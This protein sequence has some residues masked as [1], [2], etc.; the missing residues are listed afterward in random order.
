[1]FAPDSVVPLTAVA[2]QPRFVLNARW[3]VK[4]SDG[5]RRGDYCECRE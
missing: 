4:R 1:M 3:T 2:A 5:S